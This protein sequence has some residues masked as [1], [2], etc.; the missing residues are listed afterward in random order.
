MLL[1]VLPVYPSAV[2]ASPAEIEARLLRAI[3][4]VK[5]Q[6]FEAGDISGFL[7]S[8][9]GNEN[10]RSYA[11]DDALIALALSSYQE[12][13][14]TTVFNGDLKSAVESLLQMQ[15]SQGD[16]SQ[17]YDF[18]NSKL[19]PSGRFYYWNAYAIMGIGYAAHVITEQNN[20]E[21]SYW[22]P[23]IDRVRSCIDT[24]LSRSQIQSGAVLFAFPNGTDRADVGYNGA[25]LMGLMH[26][27]AFEYYW[28]SRRVAET[29]AQYSKRIA[30]WLMGLQE[31]SSSSWGYGGFYF[32]ESRSLEPTLQNALAVFGINGYY[33]GAS[34]LLPNQQIS[35][36][37]L[38]TV[39]RDWAEGYV[40]RIM[41]AWGGV[42]YGRNSS[43]LISYPKLTQTTSATLAAMVDVWIDLGPPV[44]WNDSSRMYGWII[45]GNERGVD[46]QTDSGG[47]FTGLDSQ[48]ILLSANLTTTALTLYAFIRAQYVSIPGTYPVQTIKSRTASVTISFGQATSSEAQV[49]NTNSGKQ[50]FNAGPIIFAIALLIALGVLGGCFAFRSLVRKNKRRGAQGRLRRRSSRERYAPC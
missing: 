32:N 46:M 47:F 24:W 15:D 21:S 36:E 43:G 14:F 6:Y 2:R 4:Y 28:G 11:E 1:A 33:K 40:E 12:T 17:Y 30:D 16:F 3:A 19:G 8:P 20:T 49:T 34:L 10:P 39:M 29:Y 31:E 13:H 26:L 44:F 25:L 23:V 42:A 9:A 22:L 38:R 5:G 18:K 48:G 45:G 50:T 27:A 41:D 35:L 37:G 7:H